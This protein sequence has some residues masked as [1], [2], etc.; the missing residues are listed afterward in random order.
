V[1]GLRQPRAP[2]ILVGMDTTY[3]PTDGWLRA[4]VHPLAG[5]RGGTT[6]LHHLLGL[7]LGIAYF[8]WLVTGIAVGAGLLITLIGIPILTLVLASIRPL[9]AAERGLANELL[10]ARIPASPLAPAANG[11]LDRLKA[12]WTD[13]RTWRGAAYLLARF[14]IGMAAF[15]VAVTAYG[16]AFLLLAA[17]VLAPTDADGLDLGAWDVDTL[18]EGLAL[19]P[20]GVVAVVAA[21]W[22]SAGMGAVSREL[23][24]LGAR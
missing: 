17:P 7:P 5:R 3:R 4:A 1:A 13:G 16:V 22:I 20:V 10:G 9:L 23:A 12:Y 21:G 19:V 18:L 15:I 8:T 24:R 2:A 14:P 11:W 6:L